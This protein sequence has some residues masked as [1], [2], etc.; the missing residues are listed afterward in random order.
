MIQHP[1][2]LQNNQIGPKGHISQNRP[3]HILYANQT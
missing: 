3:T 2:Y 1:E